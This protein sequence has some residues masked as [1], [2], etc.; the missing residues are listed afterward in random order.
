MVVTLLLALAAL[1]SARPSAQSPAAA[2]LERLATA[3]P[4]RRM[5]LIYS[6][7]ASGT[8]SKVR[9]ERRADFRLGQHLCHAPQLRH[10]SS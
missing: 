6:C 9:H 7:L 5:R 2:A 8:H 3:V 10:W 1:L 4:G